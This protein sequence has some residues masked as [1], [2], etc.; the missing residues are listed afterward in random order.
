MFLVRRKWAY[1]QHKGKTEDTCKGGNTLTPTAK[2]LN[3]KSISASP[4]AAGTKFAPEGYENWNAGS[5]SMEHMAPDASAL[6][7]YKP[8]APGETV[9][10]SD[11]TLVPVQGYDGL[12]LELQWTGGTTAV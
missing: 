1:P 10:V 9:E 3:T 2:F 5:R 11:Q 7:D 8:A 6:I 12:E 4:G